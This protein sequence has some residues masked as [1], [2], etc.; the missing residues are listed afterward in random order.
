MDLRV[1]NSLSNIAS[2]C[3]ECKLIYP[4]FAEDFHS[5]KGNQKQEY[6]FFKVEGK[7]LDFIKLY[8]V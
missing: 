8:L 5:C 1:L 3:T 6:P 2:C 4:E 7:L